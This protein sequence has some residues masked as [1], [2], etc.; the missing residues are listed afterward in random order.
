MSRIRY[1]LDEDTP[2]TIRDQLLR[3]QP[4]IEV[5]AVGDQVAPVFGTPDADVLRWIELE[6]YIIR[7]VAQLSHLFNTGPGV[8]STPIEPK[9]PILVRKSAL[10][11]LGAP[12]TENGGYAFRQSAGLRTPLEKRISH[13]RPTREPEQ[14]LLGASAH[15]A[16][17]PSERNRRLWLGYTRQRAGRDKGGV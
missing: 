5:L 14:A 13:R 12:S 8:L 3:R 9:T 7:D 2:H 1:L 17:L 11:V 15:Q 4:S 6:G 16:S 10:V